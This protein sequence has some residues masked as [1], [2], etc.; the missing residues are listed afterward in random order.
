[1]SFELHTVSVIPGTQTAFGDKLVLGMST[2]LSTPASAN[3]VTA[4]GSITPGTGASG[5]VNSVVLT[6][7][8]GTGSG[9]LAV[10]TSFKAVTATVV[11]QGTSGFATSDT[12]TLDNGVVLTV[13]AVS[14][15][16][17]TTANVTTAGSFTSVD[18]TVVHSQTA[19]SGSGVGTTTWT[20]A[21]GLGTAQ[22]TDSGNYSGAP[23][24]T[25]AGAGLSGASIATGT[26][27]GNGNTIYKFLPFQLPGNYNVQ[28]TPGLDCRA[29][30]PP[31]LKFTSGFSVAL[32]PTTTGSTLAAGSIDVQVTA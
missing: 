20:L 29:Y 16:K 3:A 22:I 18:P 1:M 30:V 24:M 25:A 13:T 28:V 10:A 23:S 15:G 19:T 11:G 8:G 27:G 17:P 12:I 5:N 14:S 7:S 26:L 9:L 31:S 6:P 4:L 21:Y 32:V 2:A